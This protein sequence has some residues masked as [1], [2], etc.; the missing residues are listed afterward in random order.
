M[1]RSKFNYLLPGL[2]ILLE[3]LIIGYF[4]TTQLQST[5]GHMAWSFFQLRLW[6]TATIA[7]IIG[8]FLG[9]IFGP[10]LT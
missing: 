7:S 5:F 4:V 6:I 10:Y 3:L 2:L 1:N 8:F 9:A